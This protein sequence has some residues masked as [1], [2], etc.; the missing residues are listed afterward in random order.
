MEDHATP[1]SAMAFM[2]PHF[3]EHRFFADGSA[4]ISIPGPSWEDRDAAALLLVSEKTENLDPSS[5]LRGPG[6]RRRYLLA[7]MQNKQHVSVQAL[8]S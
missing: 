1:Y 3:C 7:K 4:A 5:E 6:P 8:L 2:I